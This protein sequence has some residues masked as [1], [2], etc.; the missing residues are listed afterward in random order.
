[1]I[2]TWL[3]CGGDDRPAPGAL[4]GDVGFVPARVALGEVPVGCDHDQLVRI[5]NRSARD[6]ELAALTLDAGAATLHDPPQMPQILH[7]GGTIEVRI[8]AVADAPAPAAGTLTVTWEDGGAATAPVSGA[9][10]YLGEQAESFV[11]PLPPADLLFAVDAGHEMGER[12]AD[13]VARGLPA[14]V[15]A[16][17][18]RA[19]WRLLLVNDASACGAVL[20]AA[21]DPDPADE[22]AQAWFDRPGSS[23]YDH[24]LLE[25]ASRALAENAEDECNRT[26]QREDTQL[27]VVVATDAPEQ[28]GIPWSQWVNDFGIGA[29]TVVVSGWVDLGHD[30]G[31]G[32]GG[33]TDAIEATGGAAVDLCGDQPLEALADAIRPV[34][35]SFRLAWVPLPDS[36]EVTV[37]GRAA[38]AHVDGADVRLDDPTPAGAA[39]EVHYALAPGCVTAR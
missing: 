33:Y 32:A 38:P 31:S 3:A 25:L 37:D 34:A 10:A 15:G 23:P 11:V 14:L 18:E 24:A 19:D 2:W 30:C 35:P 36:V 12:Y 28:S 26:F 7:P 22:L 9:V 1:M 29:P 17:N 4:S 13:D 20:A 8:R 6:H 5:V 27:H 16:L 39:V 21:G